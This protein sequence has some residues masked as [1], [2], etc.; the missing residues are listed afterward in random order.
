MISESEG[1]LEFELVPLFILLI[2]LL[3]E[4]LLEKFKFC[5]WVSL[6]SMFYQLFDFVSNLFLDNFDYSAILLL[7]W[8]L[9]E[10]LKHS[11]KFFFQLLLL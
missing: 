10:L 8:E 3:V 1:A 5:G 2:F 4:L 11:F 9:I 6:I 7:L